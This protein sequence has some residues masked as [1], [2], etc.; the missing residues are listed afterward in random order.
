MSEL[1]YRINDADE[2]YYES[3]DCFTR[4]IERAFRERTVRVERSGDG[5]GRMWVGDERCHFF[6]VGVGDN[7]GPPGA[8]K[9]FLRGES[10]EGGNPSLRAI[11]ALG[12]ASF[13]TGT[14]LRV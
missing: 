6:S 14:D 1:G 13:R 8:M 2:H 7:V 5:P 9:A 10:E 11:D 4:H 12:L 3:D